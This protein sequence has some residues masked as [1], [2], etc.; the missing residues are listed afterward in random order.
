VCHKNLVEVHIQALVMTTQFQLQCWLSAAEQSH[1]G[2]R[3]LWG[4]PLCSVLTGVDLAI[5]TPRLHA[6][7]HSLCSLHTHRFSKAL[8]CLCR[9]LQVY[10]IKQYPKSPRYMDL[11]PIVGP[12]SMLL[13]EGHVWKS[14]REAFNP[15]ECC[16]SWRQARRGRAVPSR[17]AFSLLE[18][19][20]AEMRTL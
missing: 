17:G 3:G 20:Q 14:Q 6:G 19:H 16:C 9:S 10:E 11:L 4:L 12:Q 8:V 2:A 13:T 15:G 1:S 18:A 5:G 7:G